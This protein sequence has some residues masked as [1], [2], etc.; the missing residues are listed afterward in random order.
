MKLT[1]LEINHKPV[2]KAAKKKEVAI[3]VKKRTRRGDK[4]YI[5]R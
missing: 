2:A 1:S 3:Q 5:A 4:V